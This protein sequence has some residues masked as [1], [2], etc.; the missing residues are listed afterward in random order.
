MI[1]PKGRK[2]NLP[3]MFCLLQQV[4][5]GGLEAF[6]SLSAENKGKS[7]IDDKV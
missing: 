5:K 6:F 1:L 2:H 7:D 4:L 3:T